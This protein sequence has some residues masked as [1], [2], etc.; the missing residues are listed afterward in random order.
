MNE[1]VPNT[2]EILFYLQKAEKKIRS[3]KLLLDQGF[4]E[5]AVSRA[6]YAGFHAIVASLRFKK[7]DLS[8]HKHVFILNQFRIHFVDT[9]ILSN[10]LYTKILNI[11][12]IREHTDYAINSEIEQI[13]AEQIVRDTQNIVDKIKEYLE[14]MSNIKS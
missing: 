11:R 4:Y 10:D 6:Y 3:A 1:K 14:K 9:K 8:R 2:K 13:E 5:D 7:V 12:A